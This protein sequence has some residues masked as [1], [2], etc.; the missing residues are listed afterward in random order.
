[1]VIIISYPS[2]VQTV[3]EKGTQNLVDSIVNSTNSDCKRFENMPILQVLINNE[4]TKP[5]YYNPN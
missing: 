5:A 1:M 4:Y 3:Y 2:A